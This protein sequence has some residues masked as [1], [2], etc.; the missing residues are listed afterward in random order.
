MENWK[1]KNSETHLNENTKHGVT[2]LTFPSLEESGL[3]RHAFSTRLGG[4]SKGPYATL[5]FSFTRGDDPEA[6]KENYKRMAEALGVDRER[7]VLT[8]QTHTTNVR[9]VSPDD[10]GKGVVKDRDYRDV[11]GLVTDMP[12]VTLVTFFADC[13]PLYF[14]D[15]KRKAIGLSHSGWRGTVGRMGAKT[16]ETMKK[17]FGTDPKDVIACVGPS[18]CQD[19]YEVGEEVI[20][21]FEQSFAKERHDRLFY[22]KEN[23][24][25]QL[26]LWEANK[27]VLLE[28][29]VPKE[30]LSV[31]DICTYCNPDLL[32][33]HRRTPEKRGNLCAFLCLRE[34]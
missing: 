17:E 26:N 10:V 25:Y 31:T 4:V 29:G 34:G 30:N 33:S 2:F 13:V 12:G 27:I 3:V 23:G 15:I 8:W 19:C 18:I 21:E 14:L 9:R 22:R 32:F 5:N 11:D 28:A 6:V 20:A 24:K 7:M 16:L 1:R